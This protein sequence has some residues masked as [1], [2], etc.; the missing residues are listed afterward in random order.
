MKAYGRKHFENVTKKSARQ[1]GQKEINE[2]IDN[3]IEDWTN[4]YYD[5]C[6]WEDYTD[7]PRPFL[8]VDRSFDYPWWYSDYKFVRNWVAA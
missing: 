3:I 8:R 6:E 5:I 7:Q 4:S 2:E 1:E